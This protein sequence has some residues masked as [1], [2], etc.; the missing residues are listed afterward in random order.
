M[1]D[2]KDNKEKIYLSL[3]NI[4]PLNQKIIRCQLTE[5]DLELVRQKPNKKTEELDSLLI[6][7]LK[8]D[9]Y[10]DF[11]KFEAEWK[12]EVREYNDYEIRKITMVQQKF[13]KHL[14]DNI[15]ESFAE[16]LKQDAKLCAE[17]YFN[18]VNKNKY[19]N[20]LESSDGK[21]HVLKDSDIGFIKSSN[22]E[23]DMKW[24][25]WE[26]NSHDGNVLF[27][28]GDV[29][30][31]NDWSYF[32]IDMLREYIEIAKGFSRIGLDS[33]FID[34]HYDTDND[35]NDCFRYLCRKIDDSFIEKDSLND[36]DCE[37]F[38]RLNFDLEK[39]KQFRIYI[40]DK[41]T[42]LSFKKN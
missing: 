41:K 8:R 16:K 6:E 40:S 20:P 21:Y 13:I 4:D 11:Q 25:E 27:S 30:G 2:E 9:R 5:F 28:L 12:N 39:T 18:F 23:D 1:N 36:E 38:N 17:S 35:G 22:C 14:L 3:K 15:S 29:L 31:I 33:W 34:I 32:D 26:D 24:F 7:L 10:F 37:I 42:R 19:T